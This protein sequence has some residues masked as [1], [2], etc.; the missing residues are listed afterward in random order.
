M[1][2]TID[3]PEKALKHAAELGISIEDL[4]S[5][6]IDTIGEEPLPVGFIRLGLARHTPEEA[7]AI[8]RDIASR[9]T[10]GGLSTK[11]LIEEG[12]RL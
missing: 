6:T 12:R 5:Q 7:T 9:N 11:E 3:I 4:V 2:M 10:L 1:V 8:I